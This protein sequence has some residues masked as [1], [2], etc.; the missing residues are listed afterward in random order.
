[1]AKSTYKTYFVEKDSDL[2]KNASSVTT[3]TPSPT[4]EGYRLFFV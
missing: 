3:V 2:T 1:M 4:E